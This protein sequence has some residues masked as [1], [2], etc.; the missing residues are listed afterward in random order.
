[1]QRPQVTRC[2]PQSLLYSFAMEPLSELEAYMFCL[3]W[4]LGGF[5]HLQVSAFLCAGGYRCLQDLC[6]ACYVGAGSEL[7]MLA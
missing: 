3:G 5:I 7:F 4:K 6:P 1:M 2:V